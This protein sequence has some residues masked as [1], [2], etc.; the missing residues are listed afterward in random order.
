[1]QG[2]E[3]AGAKLHGTSLVATKLQGANLDLAELQGADL[4]FVKLQ[5]AS[6]WRAEMQGIRISNTML[7]GTYLQEVEMQGASIIDSDMQGASLEKSKLH[8]AVID[9]VRLDGASLAR[10]QLQGSNLQGSSLTEAFISV[11]YV[12]RAQNAACLPGWM[13]R[14]NAEP[15]IDLRDKEILATQSA[16]Q[17]FINKSLR[18]LPTD[19]KVEVEEQMRGR[20]LT[21][22]PVESEAA[23]AR[24][25]AA[26]AGMTATAPQDAYDA[27]HADLLLGLVCGATEYG[28]AI[29]AGVVRNWLS[30]DIQSERPAFAARLARGLLG[31]DGQDCPAAKEW[32]EKTR[33]TLQALLPAAAPPTPARPPNP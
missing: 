3:L 26:C 15:I 20:L 9:R 1:L 10:T 14:P 21:A 25:W 30:A 6:L 5:G 19:S 11:A 8:A 33:R 29:G 2:A 24:R 16:I 12:W 18:G 13:I 31:L 28:K 7:Q 27:R 4:A 17:D 22:M 23:V 32:D